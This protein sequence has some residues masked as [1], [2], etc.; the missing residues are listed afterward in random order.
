MA[1]FNEFSLAFPA[2]L[3]DGSRT[4]QGSD[5]VVAGGQTIGATPSFRVIPGVVVV[6]ESGDGLYYLA[7]A[8]DGVNAGDINTA[9]EVTS[10]E[11]ADTDWDGTVI[12]STA[13]Y[14]DG[15]VAACPVTLA[16]TDDTTAEVVAALNANAAFAN[17]FVASGTDGNPVVITARV[18][19]K[20]T[21][22]VQQTVIATGF[23]TLLVGTSATGTEADYRVIAQHGDLQD[24]DG[25]AAA[26]KPLAALTAGRF[27][28][29]ELLHLSNEARAVLQGR[30]STFE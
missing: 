24:L 1:V 27:K 30:G 20:V 2:F 17:H 4:K 25:D 22:N 12:T 15:L 5:V 9:A 14:P 28:T 8:A 10:L 21:I 11:P 18:K 13:F 19:G 16:G 26:S 29:S 3:V 23:G 7:D 6:K